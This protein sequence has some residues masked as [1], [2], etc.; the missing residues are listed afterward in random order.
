M[1]V[2]IAK[3]L[4]M[5]S[6]LYVLL[7]EC[8]RAVHLRHDGYASEVMQKHDLGMGTSMML[9]SR[10]TAPFNE[11]GCLFQYHRISCISKGL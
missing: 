9:L 8:C 10:R 3:A 11:Y 7:V 5:R 6:V 4:E 2:C 1:I